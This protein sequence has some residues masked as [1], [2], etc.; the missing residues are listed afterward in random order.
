ME[1]FKTWVEML[2][3]TSYAKKEKYNG[4]D[5]YPNLGNVKVDFIVL[6]RVINL[7]TYV[8]H[9]DN[10]EEY[11]GYLN[12]VKDEVSFE[13]ILSY[14]AKELPEIEQFASIGQTDN[15]LIEGNVGSI[16]P[17]Y[18]LIISKN[19]IL[20]MS[21]MPNEMT[22][23]YVLIIEYMRDLY[24]KIYGRKPI[25]FEHG[26][27][28]CKNPKANSID[29]AHTHVVNHTYVDE[30]KVIS[31]LGLHEVSSIDEMLKYGINK[32]YISY[33][34]PSDKYYIGQMVKEESQIMRKFIAEDIG[35][36]DEWDWRKYP[37][38]ENSFE[39]AKH[40]LLHTCKKSKN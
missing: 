25:I 39:T 15:F 7:L 11:F 5:I 16:V 31:Y 23:E 40:Y 34:S 26:S 32:N 27:N 17:G 18:N 28:N 33:V 14:Y 24:E 37:H 4:F 21:A 13:P 30:D 6:R 22:R 29:H 1:K 12:M 2:E 20:S 36:K 35:K 9:Y 3:Q 38:P 10:I 8:G 19:H